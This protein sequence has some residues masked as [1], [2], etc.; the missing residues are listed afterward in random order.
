MVSLEQVRQLV[1]VAMLTVGPKLRGW[2]GWKSYVSNPGCLFLF[3]PGVSNS[4]L[5]RELGLSMG[6]VGPSHRGLEAEGKDRWPVS[7]LYPLA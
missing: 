5:E 7:F 6:A 2:L 3:R 1:P 4:S